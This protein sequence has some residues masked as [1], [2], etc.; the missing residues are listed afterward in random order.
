MNIDSRPKFDENL[1]T[2]KREE[3]EAKK[4]ETK[5]IVTQLHINL[6]GKDLEFKACKEPYCV[7]N[8]HTH[9]CVRCLKNMLCDALDG[10]VKKADLIYKRISNGKV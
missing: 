10:N 5:N 8:T 9:F 3:K 2:K 1:A 6:H 4:L 7:Y